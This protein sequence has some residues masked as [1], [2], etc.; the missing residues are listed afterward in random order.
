[1]RF[2]L[3][4]AQQASVRLL[5][6]K[7]LVKNQSADDITRSLTIPRM[8]HLVPDDAERM[9]CPVRQLLLY[10]HDKQPQERPFSSFPALGSKDLG[11]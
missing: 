10:K 4:A 8:K 1:M 9:L 5:P 3:S 7:V 6:Y 2:S 11:Y